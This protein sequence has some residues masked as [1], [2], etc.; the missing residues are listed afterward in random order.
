M[1]IPIISGAISAPFLLVF[2]APQPELLW[3][4]LSVF[5]FSFTHSFGDCNTSPLTSELLPRNLWSTAFGSLN[6]ANCVAGGI[7]VMVAG[8][9]KPAWGWAGS[10]VEF[11]A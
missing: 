4:N 3:L 2:L 1:L 5:A 10:F 9:L 11:P 8:F 6:S 7:G